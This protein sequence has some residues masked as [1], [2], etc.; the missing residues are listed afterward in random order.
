MYISYQ[1]LQLLPSL[2]PLKQ[3]LYYFYGIYHMVENNICWM[4]EWMKQ[5][6]CNFMYN[7]IAIKPFENVAITK[8]LVSRLV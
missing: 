6:S 3:S 5:V 8:D 4:S 7:A 2:C 1:L